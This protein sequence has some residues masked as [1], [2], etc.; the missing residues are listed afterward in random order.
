MIDDATLAHRHKF[1]V[2]A[3]CEC[4]VMLS[5]LIRSQEAEIRRLREHEEELRRAIMR[6]PLPPTDMGDGPDER[7]G[8]ALQALAA[9]RAVIRELADL[10]DVD[11]LP[12]FANE[13]DMI[14]WVERKNAALAHPLVQQAREEKP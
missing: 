13:G 6:L 14:A 5:A 3:S 10:L 1:P 7:V 2:D 8:H 11:A 12:E 4:G 9:H